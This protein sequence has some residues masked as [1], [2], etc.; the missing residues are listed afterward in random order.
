MKYRNLRIAWSVGWGMIAVVLW[1]R[2]YSALDV[3][4]SR[5]VD[6]D[7]FSAESKRGHLLIQVF[8]T[9]SGLLTRHGVSTYP[10]QSSI[11]PTTSASG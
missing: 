7:W 6:P 4:Q 8:R 3:V 1:V 10:I 9:E 5:I 2:S 11:E